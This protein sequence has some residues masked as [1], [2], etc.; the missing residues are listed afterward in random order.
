MHVRNRKLP[1]EGLKNGYTANAC[2]VRLARR[3]YTAAETFR[4]TCRPTGYRMDGIPHG[5]VSIDIQTLRQT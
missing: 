3:P 4:K 2:R 1:G 5:C